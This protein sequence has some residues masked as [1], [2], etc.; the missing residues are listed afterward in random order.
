LEKQKTIEK[1]F[2]LEGKGLQTGKPVKAFFYPKK[3]DEGIIFLRRDLPGKPPIRLKEYGA[4]KFSADRRS[5]V[6]TDGENFVE[7][8]EHVLA[9]SWAAGVDNMLIELDSSEMPALD[10]SAVQ[11]LRA[12]KGSG[13]KEQEKSREPIRVKEPIWVEEGESFLGIFPS[14]SFKI[15]CVFEHPYPACGRQFFSE[16]ISASVF[17]REIAPARTLWF[18]PP[19]PEPIENKAELVKKLGYGRGAN[20]ENTLVIDEREMIN[21]ARFP[22]EPVRHNVTDLIG[23]LYLLGR[24]L[25]ARVIAVRTNHRLNQELVR[26]IND[27]SEGTGLICSTG[28]TA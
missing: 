16:V 3:E 1:A 8:T 26:K 18:V 9:A 14:D 28:S 5:I 4:L 12:L 19:G 11:F 23:D 13:L 7:T 24:P 10:G 15:S 20:L 17:E 27:S 21:T 6:G 22:D 25:K 2:T